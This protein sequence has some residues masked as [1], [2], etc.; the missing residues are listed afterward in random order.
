MQRVAREISITVQTHF[1]PVVDFRIF[2]AVRIGVE[3]ADAGRPAAAFDAQVPH[4]LQAVMHQLR[5][6]LAE[7]IHEQ[8]A[9]I[10][11]DF[12]EVQTRTPLEAAD[13]V[14]SGVVAAADGHR[15]SL[16]KFVEQRRPC[17][18][19]TGESGVEFF[20]RA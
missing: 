12:D 5:R 20:A 15:P 4:K 17:S 6:Q 10:G 9:L 14:A 7:K 2:T 1:Q 13:D 3:N 19:R 11:G 8:R 16:H 18:N